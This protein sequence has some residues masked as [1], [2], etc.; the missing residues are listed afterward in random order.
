MD[1]A[2]TPKASLII[3][4]Y[5]QSDYLEKVFESLLKQSFKNFEILIADDGS[6]IELSEI[7]NKYQNKFEYP[8]KHIRHEDKGFRKTII[9]NNTVKNSNSDYIIFI[10]GDCILH[11]H[12]IKSHLSRKE[13]KVVLSGRRIMFDKEISAKISLRDI[14]NSKYE[15]KSFWWNN[16]KPKDRKRGFYMPFLY[17]LINSGKKNYWVFGSNFSIHK[18]DFISVNGYDQNIIGR[19]L[20]DVNLSKRFDLRGYKINRLTYEALQ[21][22]LFHESKPIP[23]TKETENLFINPNNFYAENGLNCF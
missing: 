10:D 15:K 22:H 4:C 5:N 8:I 19:G 13:K 7:I 18:E 20:E 6:G 21:Y 1:A 17:K 23:H 16:C 9:V 14:K 11:H 2:K 12:F 3:A